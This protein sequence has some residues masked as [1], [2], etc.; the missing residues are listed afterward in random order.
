MRTFEIRRL[1]G[2]DFQN[3]ISVQNDPWRYERDVNKHQFTDFL[4]I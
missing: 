1:N 3:F 2:V 4:L